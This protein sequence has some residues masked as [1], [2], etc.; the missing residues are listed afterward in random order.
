MCFHKRSFVSKGNS[1]P[2]GASGWPVDDLTSVV[3]QYP[4]GGESAFFPF[5]D[6][7]KNASDMSH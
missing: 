6:I 4:C 3:I 1:G 2:C 7:A 5:V